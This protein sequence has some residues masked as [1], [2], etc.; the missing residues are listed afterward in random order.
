MRYRDGGEVRVAGIITARKTKVLKNGDTMAFLTVEDD[1]GEIET[2]VFAK[3]YRQLSALLSE[4]SAVLITGQ[5]SAE[6]DAPPKLMFRSAER[7][8]ENG[9]Q[10]SDRG[11]EAQRRLFIKVSETGEEK[12]API[13][14]LA[15]LHPGDAQIVLYH[16][17]T[18]KYS[19]IRDL[20]IDPSEKVLARLGAL[21]GAENVVLR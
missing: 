1:S 17:E 20:S 4:E 11:T 2:I 12:I 10:R 18:K 16:T 3:Y 5:L 9:A 19:A 8:A 14:R 21:Y 15:S 6:E 7:L 13:F